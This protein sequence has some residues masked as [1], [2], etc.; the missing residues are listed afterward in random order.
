MERI[1]EVSLEGAQHGAKSLREFLAF[2]KKAGAPGAQPSSFQLQAKDGSLLSAKEV[3]EVF[4]SLGMR[5]HGVSGHCHFWVL[6][7]AHTGSPTIKPFIPASVASLSVDKI[8]EWCESYILRLFDVCA[9]MGVNIMPMFWGLYWGWEV[10]SGYPWSFWQGP[11]YDLIKEGDERFLAKTERIRQE[12]AA[13]GIY[14][15]H[16]IHPNTGASCADDFL[17]MRALVDKHSTYRNC[18]VVQADPSHSWAGED[19]QTRFAKVGH[20]IYGVHMKNHYVRKGHPLLS[21]HSDWKDRG[22]QFCMLDRGDIDMVRFT[23]LFFQLLANNPNA[24][25]LI[26]Q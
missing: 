26:K 15:C 1:F 19:W 22:M 24:F 8:E 16:E 23:E 3:K 7:T 20:L 10:A 9:A 6:G 17:H 13:R 4:D 21:M 25:R 5:C 14:L 2:A 12:A 11:G 18:V